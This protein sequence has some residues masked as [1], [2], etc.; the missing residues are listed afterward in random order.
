MAERI[1]IKS[2]S[3]NYKSHKVIKNMN[4]TFPGGKIIGILGPNG[5]GKS[6]LIKMLAGVLQPNK[7]QILI[8]GEPVGVKSK[9]MVSYLPERTYLNPSKKVSD[10]I[11]FFKDFYADF[12]P[13]RANAMLE[14]FGVDPQ[15]KIKS[16]SKGMREKVQ[17]VLVMSRNA[18]LYLLDEPMGG[19][20]PAAR[21]YILRTIIEN[22]NEDSTILI[23]TH[24]IS[25]IEK[26]LDDVVFIRDGGIF[27]NDSVD[28]IRTNY[29]KSVD[30][31]FREHIGLYALVFV[32]ALTEI[33]LD[34]FEFDLVSV[35]FWALHSLSVIAMFICSLVIIVIYFRRNLLKDE[36][37]LMNTLPVEPWKLYV[38]KFL[39]AFVL[40]IL[41]LIVAILSFSIINQGF[42][43]IGDII[44]GMS[45][46]FANAGFTASP[47]VMFGSIAIISLLYMISMLFFSLTTGYRANGSKDAY[48]VLTFI[49]LYVIG[50][51]ANIIVMIFTYFIP[52][53]SKGSITYIL[54]VLNPQEITALINRVVIGALAVSLILTVVYVAGSI[55]N[56]TKKLNLE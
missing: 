19:V 22:Y 7:G 2:L 10:I 24:L 13:E 1:E 23:T 5:S 45:D 49:I 3:K 14:K 39:T 21:D 15:A 29:K 32:S 8:D 37:Y 55:Y 56:M 47:V 51:V 6:T 33:I 54:T 4:V 34:S 27:L 35:F 38:S 52:L 9:A 28:N 12:S 11:A 26:V 30:E 18:K 41:D 43:W 40:F 16:L 53:S 31:L 44:R 36:G 25:D 20:D 50:Q 17:I 42:A 48:S 46:E